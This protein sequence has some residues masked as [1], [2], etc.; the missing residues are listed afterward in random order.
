MCACL[1]DK[2]LNLSVDFAAGQKT[3]FTCAED[4]RVLKGDFVV[5]SVF[6]SRYS[7]KISLLVGHNLSTTVNLFFADDRAGWLW[8]MLLFWV[9][10][11]YAPN[12]IDERRSFI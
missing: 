6:G 2:L 8:L 11:V 7:A 1:L 9:V 3:H 10:V 5:F 4:C 12:S